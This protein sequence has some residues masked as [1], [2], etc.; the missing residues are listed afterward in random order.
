MKRIKQLSI[1]II[2][3]FAMTVT[4]PAWAAPK[5]GC[6][7]EITLTSRTMTS[8][9]ISWCKASDNNYPE[10][11]LKYRV[12]W[13]KKGSSLELN[14]GSNGLVNVSSYTIYGLEAGTEY[15]VYIRVWNPNTDMIHY[16]TKKFKTD[17]D[18]VNPTPGKLSVV[19]VTKNSIALSWT[20]A[21]DNSTLQSQLRYQIN[22]KKTTE[23][24]YTSSHTVN[25][26]PVDITSYTITGLKPDTEYDVS[27]H[28]RDQADN[29]AWYNDLVVKTHP[30]VD[31]QYPTPGSYGTITSTT[32]TIAVN[33]TRGSDNVTPQNKLR[34]R[35]EWRKKSAGGGWSSSGSSTTDM[36]GYLITGLEP[37]TEYE[38]DV[39][40]VDEADNGS[41]YGQRTIKTKA[42]PDT[43]DPTPGS[44]GTITSTANSLT[45]RWTHGTDNV[46]PQ[47]GLKY[48][49]LWR[50]KST[51]GWIAYVAPTLG[52]LSYTITNLTPDTEYEFFAVIF[53]AAGN[54][55]AYPVKTA[56]TLKPVADTQDPT[57]GSYGTITATAN[58]IIVNWTRGTDN[59][60]PQNKL[61]YRVS[62]KR[63]SAS[64]W[65]H[66]TKFTNITT[67]TLAGLESNTVYQVDVLVYD[68]ANN[69]R[70]YG[71]RT[72]KTKPATIAVTG[73]TL[74][75][76]S[77]SL[78]V[79]QTGGL[80]ATVA[81]ATATNKKVTWTSSNTAVATV[82]GSGT[83][84]GIAPGTATITVK[85]VDGGKTATAAVTVK[86]ATAPT[87]KVS[88]VT[89]NRNTFTVNGDYEEVQLTATV[90]PSNATDKSLTWSS[91]NPQVASVDANGLVTI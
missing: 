82:D 60:T 40:V 37:N 51:T 22:W 30:A 43:Q 45:V 87:V 17:P 28:V 20:K 15:E 52:M 67:L 58:S 91:D 73:V 41:W 1:W 32:T 66:G 56:R 53:D 64:E 16:K 5:P 11:R 49:I 10:D 38:L 6:G 26:L 29:G 72:V 50:K 23:S 48:R 79:G 71:Q 19:G 88:D 9:S 13:K 46:T 42:A 74:S 12:V 86:A 80:T 55:R 18:K 33:W 85:T 69:Y 8:L 24:T 4:N 75:P 65:T 14:S 25:K 7:G 84:K 31:T 44:Y 81:P 59:I 76:A 62:W 83:V 63:M 57:P 54:S 77:L 36:T 89:L 2:A 27:V 35:L 61:R 90:A 3:L 34:Y 70:W 68:E 39:I 21:T 47:S 78:E